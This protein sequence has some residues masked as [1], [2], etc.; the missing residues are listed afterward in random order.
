MKNYVQS[1][2]RMPFTAGADVASGDPVIVGD[3]VGIAV[4][5][6]ANGADGELQLCG[7]FELAKANAAITAADTL[8]WDAGNSN[9]TTTASGNTKIGFA[10][11][12]AA[13]GAATAMVKLSGV[14]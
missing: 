9:V 11:A 13:L 10:F 5:D 14:V 12:P 6:V 8:Y 4:G 3:I 1:G 2:N 7:V